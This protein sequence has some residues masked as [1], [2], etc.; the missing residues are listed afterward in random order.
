MSDVFYPLFDR[1]L[2]RRKEAETTTA[3][4]LYLA[5]VAQEKP[6]EGEVLAVGDD[7]KKVKQFDRILFGR[8]D[9]QEITISGQPLIIMKE[10][11]ALGILRKPSSSTSAHAR[12]KD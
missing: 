3:G 10:E 8:H 12:P 2:V 1:I 11:S 5:P 4:G 7:C 6:Q 9:G